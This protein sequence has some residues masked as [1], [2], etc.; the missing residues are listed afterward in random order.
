MTNQV[1]VYN[2]QRSHFLRLT[3]CNHLFL[4]SKIPIIHLKA[5]A[6]SLLK[7]TMKVWMQNSKL[8]KP[9]KKTLILFEAKHQLILGKHLIQIG[10]KKN[11]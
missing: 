6:W 3:G 11:C 10:S 4:L 8:N 2:N 5:K 1:K 9:W 7:W